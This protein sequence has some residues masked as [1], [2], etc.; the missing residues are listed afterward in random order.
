[1]SIS[2]GNA[3]LSAGT[4]IEWRLPVTHPWIAGTFDVRY[5]EFNEDKNN[6]YFDP[7]R[8]DSELLTVAV[9]DDRRDGFLYWRIEGTYGRQA[10]TEGT[11]DQNETVNGVSAHAGIRFGNRRAALEGSYARSDNALD[12]A[13]GV[14]YSRT[15]FFFR[16]RF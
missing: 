4:A 3:R 11:A 16:L 13:Q 8:Y 5:R 14:R 2:D 15:G 9:W 7:L 12:V 10:F 6:G 1:M